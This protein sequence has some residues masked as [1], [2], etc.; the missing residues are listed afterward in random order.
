MLVT[1]GTTYVN[2]FGLG[3]ALLM[4]LLMLFLPRRHA[5]LPAVALICFETMG[6]RVMIG[7]LNFTM[8][9]LLLV[10]GAVRVLCRGEASLRGAAPLDRAI[11]W[12]VLCSIVAY[13]LLWKTT[14]AFVN[15]LG[16]AYDALGLFF[17]FRVLVRDLDD[18]RAALRH[19]ARC[20]IVLGACMLVEKSTGHNPFAALGGVEPI[21][22]VRDGT[23]R[24][25]G[26]FAHPIL[27]GTFGGAMVPLFLG[28]KSQGR[29]DTLLV[30]GG[31]AAA[32]AVVVCAGS[33]GPL[34]ATVV[35]VLGW[36]MFAL[37]RHMRLVRRALFATVVVLHLVMQ[38]P[39][40]FLLGRMTVFDG[41]TGF[42]RSILIDHTV[43]HFA[44][45]ALVGVHSTG[46]WGYHMFDVTNTYVVQAVQGGLATLLLFVLVLVRGFSAAGGAVQRWGDGHRDQQRLAWALGCALLFH[47]VNFVSVFYFDQNIVVWYL[48]LAMLATCSLLPRPSDAPAVAAGS[49]PASR[50]RPPRPRRTP[51]PA[52][53]LEPTP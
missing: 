24:C 1:D 50:E 9:R 19:L 3:L 23:L 15:R 53:G 36:W 2:G 45:W 10:F 16:M 25:Q 39:V 48:V 38:A 21:T 46:D 40:W 35:S 32:L 30:A 47:A 26:P 18:I 27:A 4:G 13:T 49:R 28:L 33:S 52:P 42:H 20:V 17:L 29:G 22:V 11:L 14:D 51:L 43:H 37:R 7:G 8:I 5:L 12:Y 44:D 41:S 31:L 34:V 6:Q